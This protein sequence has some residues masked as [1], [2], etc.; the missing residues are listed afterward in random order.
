MFNIINN[1]NNKQ[2]EEKKLTSAVY[3]PRIQPRSINAPQRMTTGVRYLPYD[4]EQRNYKTQV[5]KRNGVSEYSKQQ[6][7][8]RRRRP[9]HPLLRN[10][11][12]YKEEQR[13]Q[14]L[15]NYSN[16]LNDLLYPTCLEML[17]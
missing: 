15:P 4:G 16:R 3:V 12:I 6:P 5:N 8:R 17:Q 13:K 14:P 11:S 1:N 7:P 10:P 9:I 2:D